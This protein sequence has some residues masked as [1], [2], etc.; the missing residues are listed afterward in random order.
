M[1]LVLVARNIIAKQILRHEVSKDAPT[2]GI[3]VFDRICRS[4]IFRNAI[5]MTVCGN[6]KWETSLTKIIDL[7]FRNAILYVPRKG[8]PENGLRCCRYCTV[9][10]EKQ[11]GQHSC[12]F[13]PSIVQRQCRRSYAVTNLELPNTGCEGHHRFST[14]VWKWYSL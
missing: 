8:V 10:A 5:N 3:L 13:F 6:V 2:E 14:L 7:E 11:N 4:V 1:S 12:Q 9:V